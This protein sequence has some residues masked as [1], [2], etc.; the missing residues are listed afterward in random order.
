MSTEP[1]QEIPVDGVMGLG[2]KDLGQV[3]SEQSMTRLHSITDKVV[4]MTLGM[5]KDPK[6]IAEETSAL[7]LRHVGYDIPQ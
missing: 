4:I 7:G 3:Y 5:F 6:R 2:F 1:F